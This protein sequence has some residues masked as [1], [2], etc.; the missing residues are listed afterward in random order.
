MRRRIEVLAAC[1]VLWVVLFICASP[2]WLAE[3]LC[4]TWSAARYFNFLAYI[5]TICVGIFAT[6]MIP[7]A[8]FYNALNRPANPGTPKEWETL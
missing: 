5:V 4:G 7:M 1:V 3:W 2:F 8:S 6:I